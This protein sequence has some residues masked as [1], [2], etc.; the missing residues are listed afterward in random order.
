VRDLD[1]VVLGASGVTGRRVAA[2]LAARA[3]AV[4]ARWAAAGRDPVRVRR[5]LEHA[6]VATPEVLAAD[7]ADPASLQAMAERTRV[8]LDL[9]GPYTT[10]GRPVVDACVTA[11]SHYV[12]LTGEIPFVRQVVDEV[13]QAATFAGVK[14]VQAC[15]FESLPP[16]LAV[17]LAEEEAHHRWRESLVDVDVE[18]SWTLPPGLPRPSDALS[19]GTLHSLL[20]VAAADLDASL[21][22]DPAALVTDPAAAEA[23]RARSP[24]TV[25]PRQGRHRD[26]LAPM[27]PAAFINPTVVHRSAYLRGTAHGAVHQPFRYRE[28]VVLH[29]PA[30]TLPLRYTAAAVLSGVQA[31][32]LQ[33]ARAPLGVRRR[34]ARLL[35]PLL[36]SPGF[37]PAPHR[38]QAWHW[39]LELYAR[40]SGGATVEVDV[41]ADGHPG[42]LATARMLG[43]AGLMLATDGATPDAAGCLTPATALGTEHVRR[44]E[45]AHL[46]FSVRPE[47][48]ATTRPRERAG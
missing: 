14:V 23:V 46:R 26:V 42:Y 2:Y 30:A 32:M 35:Q 22:A 21:V 45:H 27:A 1:V 25:H 11:G 39:R 24:I 47:T 20:A 13:D 37:G 48:T 12:D 33:V 29:G 8:V 15:G 28:G 31:S 36:P 10:F 4:G 5:Q 9:V 7:V 44:F 41:D 19:G 6:G 34:I 38:L 16:D 3:P 18:V 40:T 43:E 17:A